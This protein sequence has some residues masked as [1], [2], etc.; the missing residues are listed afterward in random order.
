ME[1]ITKDHELAASQNPVTTNISKLRELFPSIVSEDKI[2]F[3]ALRQLLGDEITEDE[4]YFRFVWPGKKQARAEALKP[5][6][7]TLR[8]APEESLDWETTKNV[9]I[10]GD[11][12]E[13]LKLLQRSY[14]GKVKM[15][16]IDPPYNTGKDFVYKDN[17]RDNLASYRENYGRKDEDGNTVVTQSERNA[18]SAGRYHSN[19]LN[20][21]YPRLQLARNLLREDGV[22]FASIDD[23]EVNNLIKVLNEVYGEDNQ[24]A[25]IA[26]KTKLT[27]NKGTH[28]APSHEYILC[29]ARSIEK[30]PQFNDEEAQASDK[31]LKLFKY[32]DDYSKYNI[33]GLYQPS[34]DSRPNQRYY[35]ECPDGSFVIPPGVTFPF[36]VFDGSF[37]KPKG[38]HDKVWRWSYPTYLEYDKSN[39]VFKKTST[40]PLINEHGEQALWNIYTK[41]YLKDR[42]KDGARPVTLINKYP[43]SEAS[44]ELIK[45]EIP[46][47]FS[48]PRRLIQ[49]LYKLL[50]EGDGEENIVL[51]FFSGSGT[52]A[53]AVLELNKEDNRNCKY[54]LVQ[55]PQPTDEKSDAHKAGYSTIAE[56][57]KERIRRVVKKIKEDASTTLSGR[58]EIKDMDLGFRVFKLDSSNIEAWDPDP[59][60]LEDNL[61]SDNIKPDR[62]E[63]DLV[64]EILLKYGLDLSLPITKRPGPDPSTGSGAAA[65]HTLYSVGGGALFLCLGA[66]ITRRAGEAILAWAEEIGAVNPKVVFR[67]TGFTSSVE[68]TNAYEVLRSGGVTDVKSV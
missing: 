1:K 4:E 31:Y 35:I 59:E 33:V 41:I 25:I 3:E 62:T 26:R 63:H 5:S 28:F 32:E 18:E 12:L 22:V 17:Y 56:I 55:L 64:Y 37:I 50:G 52:T 6:T 48:K 10:E 60:A 36:D 13:V 46:F 57:G 45:L 61:F 2:D 9:Y 20:M 21:M 65:R 66:G 68:K 54:I 34:L 29:Y 43:N 15:I 38:N 8:P 14:A 7:G 53:Q 51:D 49:Y 42:L 58:E 11:N 67:D 30:L 27:S 44:K 23:V 19:W 47:P 24:V 40:S 16:Y 39:L